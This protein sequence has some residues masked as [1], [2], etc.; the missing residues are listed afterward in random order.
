MHALAPVLSPVAKSQ[1]EVLPGGAAWCK[2]ARRLGGA[3]AFNGCNLLLTLP[4]SLVIVIRLT[5]RRAAHRASVG[6]IQ[7]KI[8]GIALDVDHSLRR[9]RQSCGKVQGTAFE[10]VLRARQLA[11]IAALEEGTWPALRVFAG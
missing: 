6:F 10:S 4:S 7:C 11:T 9:E 2:T 8:Q 3:R 5:L 1:I